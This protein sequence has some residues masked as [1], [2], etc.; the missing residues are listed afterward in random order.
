MRI[1]EIR[2]PR[3]LSDNIPMIDDRGERFL[4]RLCFRHFLCDR[5]QFR[6]EFCLF[7]RIP[8]RNAALAYR[9]NSLWRE[10]QSVEIVVGAALLQF[11]LRAAIRRGE[12]HAVITD[13]QAVLRIGEIEF[14]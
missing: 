6:R 11:P 1:G 8:H 9:D 5:R 14:V 3:C 2:L 7:Y 10:C 4:F 12:H 13:N